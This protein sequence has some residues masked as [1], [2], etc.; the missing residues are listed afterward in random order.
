MSNNH[1]DLLNFPPGA[2]TTV[3]PTSPNPAYSRRCAGWTALIAAPLAWFNIYCYLAAV[4]GDMQAMFKPATA[5]ALSPTAQ[6]WFRVGMLAD[7]FG[8]YLPFLLVGGYL[9]SRLRERGGAFIDMAVL[10]LVV[11]VLLGVAGTSMQ[12]AALP[13]LAA[14][15]ASGDALAK[16][17]SESAWLAVVHAT[18][19]GLWWM[20]GPVMAC[21]GLIMGRALRAE[22]WGW[23]RLLMACAGLY[24]AG[25]VAQFLGAGQL[26]EGL[27]LIAVMLLPL[28]LLLTGIALLRQK[29]SM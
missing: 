8:Y 24:G 14:V 17:A 20:E 3:T 7:S 1:S 9:W 13:P 25:F 11:Y 18:E 10:C 27:S 23:G 29:E 4:G 12:I 28:W 6:Q 21:W 22:G 26:A 16:A 15:H 5:L 19:R 2:G